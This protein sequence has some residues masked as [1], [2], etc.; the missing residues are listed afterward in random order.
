MNSDE[1]IIIENNEEK[2]IETTINSN[3]NT[4]NQEIECSNNEE[5]KTLSTNLETN[6]LFEPEN[7]IDKSNHVVFNE[8]NH[9]AED[10][11]VQVEMIND[12]LEKIINRIVLNQ[13]KILN[14]SEKL[15]FIENI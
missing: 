8:T 12:R 4:F 2:I 7:N 3:I 9:F 6:N 5:I 14:I 11:K 1:N 15:D 10:L 13:K